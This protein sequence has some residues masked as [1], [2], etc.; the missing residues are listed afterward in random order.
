VVLMRAPAQAVF[1]YAGADRV[2]RTTWRNADQ[3]PA[4]IRVSVRDAATERTLA[5]SSATLLHIGAPAECARAQVARDC[6]YPPP[7]P[8]IVQ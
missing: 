3:L 2:W 8:Q 7:K 5:V 4:A 6:V 1:S